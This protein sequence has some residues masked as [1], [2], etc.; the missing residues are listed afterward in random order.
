MDFNTLFAQ[1]GPFSVIAVLLGVVTKLWLDGKS[2]DQQL[3]SILTDWRSD[4]ALSNEKLY[5]ALETLKAVMA[6]SG[7]IK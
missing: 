1:G 3:I 2:K 6:Q 4:T 5:A 7:R